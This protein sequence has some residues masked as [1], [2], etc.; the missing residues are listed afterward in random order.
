M[1]NELGALT[2]IAVPVFYAV[3]AWLMLRLRKKRAKTPIA[4]LLWLI[5][6]AL[7]APIA[8]VFGTSLIAWPFGVEIVTW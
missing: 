3:A 8:A 7:V 4:N 2:I 6:I 5:G 1:R